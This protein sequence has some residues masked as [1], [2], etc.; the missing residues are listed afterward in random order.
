MPASGRRQG[1]QALGIIIKFVLKN[2][3]EKKLRTL[4]ILVSVMLSSALFFASEAISDT[5]AG[6]FLERLQ[7]Y[8]GNAD[9]LI[10][11]TEKSPSSFFYRNRAEEYADEL[12]Y[13]VGSI[14][15]SATLTR[16]GETLRFRVNGFTLSE[17]EKLNPFFLSAENNLLPFRGK[18]L[19]ISKKAAAKYGFKLGDY[20]E[21]ELFGAKRKFYIA[22]L[23]EPAGPFLDDSQNITVV[24]PLDTLATILNARG[25]VATLYLKVKDPARKGE[26]IEKLKAAYPRY[27][28]A[29]IISVQE[30]KEY[31]QDVTTTFQLMG[32]IVLF[33]AIYIINTSFK[34]ITRER[35]PV[36]GTFRSIGATRR[37]TNLVLLAES[38]AY[39]VIGGLLGCGLGLVFLYLMS[40]T[41]LSAPGVPVTIRYSPVQLGQAFL[42]AVLIALVS[43][44]LPILKITKIPVKEIIF[45]TVSKPPR[46]KRG[47]TVL[48]L[49]LIA[50]AVFFPSYMYHIPFK[51]LL[52]VS[53][54]LLFSSLIGC[55]LLI[56]DLTSFFLTIFARV[57]RFLFGNEGILAAKNLRGNKGIL[58]NISL[59]AI[60]ISSLL[61][62]NTLSSSV[63]IEVTNFYRDCDFQIW[64]WFWQADRNLEA[65]LR[66]IDGVEGVY[67]IYAA[68]YV[69]VTNRDDRINLIHGINKYK[70]LDYW[71]LN[72]AP[73]LLAELDTGR[74]ILLTNV[75]RERLQVQKGDLLTLKTERGE[76]T[77]EVI[78]FFDCLMWNSNYA[79]ITDKYMKM[80]MGRQYYDDLCLKTSL[81]PDLVSA[82]LKKRLE[83]RYPSISTLAEMEASDQEN[84][85]TFFLVMQAFSLLA[86]FIGTF[87]VF[88]NLIISFLERQRMLAILRSVGMSKNQA[89]KMFLIEAL[90]GGLIGGMVGA[91]GGFLLISISPM[92]LKAMGTPFPIHH[93]L[94]LYL[95]SI[96]AGIFITVTASTS[97]AMKSSKLDLITAL[98][99]E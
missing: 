67:G 79:L 22:A 15:T 48:G 34:V 36:I 53:M 83:R 96:L 76:R 39:G 6:W 14:E 4:L 12:E 56:P 31:T 27:Q 52:P 41:I 70:H 17:L 51:F 78:G 89:L 8:Y 65:I 25:R 19:I 10:Y 61:M 9:L 73:E 44:F 21:L 18:K 38:L 43:S 55:I 75:L 16:Q 86:L 1:R 24:V 94:S 71:K 3:W 87:G 57:Y 5:A 88:N 35:L 95:S 77:Y 74:K 80:D 32:T 49:I 81:D 64:C 29:E 63:A 60:G 20:L 98:K 30:L 47:K 91:F 13:I 85:N 58:N 23:A 11:A 42:L 93:S 59:L 99:Y 7:T 62:I 82:T 45:N 54:L 97:P 84:N 37:M 50:G 69:E 33:M 72:I 40:L 46:R 28:V 66:K 2:I 26:L 68:N 92:L 90:T